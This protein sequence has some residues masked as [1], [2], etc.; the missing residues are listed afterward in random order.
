M[1]NH[2]DST[3]GY[4]NMNPLLEQSIK[5]LVLSSSISLVACG[6]SSSGGSSDSGGNNSGGGSFPDTEATITADNSQELAVASASAAN[7][8][9]NSPEVP[10]P[11]GSFAQTLSS[12]H[13]KAT[14]IPNVCDSGS[15]SFDETSTSYTIYY[16]DCSL[17]GASFDGTATVT[18]T[19]QAAFENGTFS[20]EYENF[21]ITAGGIS[22]TINQSISCVDDECTISTIF[23]GYTGSTY[24][25]TNTTSFENGNGSYTVNGRVSV[26]TYGYVDFSST[27]IA[28]DCSDGRPSSGTVS[29]TAG[30]VTAT[31][32]F[33][34]CSEYVVT[35]NGNA[36]SFSW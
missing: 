25:V 2:N 29:F 14:S 15:V 6:G 21:T 17:Q 32:S 16:D 4:I 5:M 8:A 10:N 35:F 3:K 28:F 12:I 20:V 9:A 1:D 34:S 19:S 11:F 18:F 27:D 7:Q 13:T 30:D 26:T 36:N 31:V 24:Q 22:Q 33:T 23:A